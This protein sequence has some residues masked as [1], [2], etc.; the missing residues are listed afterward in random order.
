MATT[1]LCRTCGATKDIT[2]FYRRA[3]SPDGLA[4]KCKI[5]ASEY[6][7]QHRTKYPEREK[8]RHDRRVASGAKKASDAAYYQRNKAQMN[9]QARRWYEDHRE[10]QSDYH[11]RYFVENRE[12]YRASRKAY[13]ARTSEKAKADAKRWASE[14]PEKVAGR[15][16]RWN[17]E[18]PEKTRAAK[19]HYKRSDAGRSKARLRQLRMAGLDA[20]YLSRQ[21]IWE[22]DSGL[23]HLCGEPAE[24]HNWHLDHVIPLARGGSH[25]Y[26]NVAV[27]H[28]SCNLRK[29]ARSA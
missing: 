2:E 27:S 1:K 14:H 8:A 15:I 9:A 24:P 7:R 10:E 17:A 18:N 19:Q 29:G 20:E 11:R 22:R 4:P 12:E 3:A 6:A 21:M 26:D 16:Q 28:P 13:Y 25:T 23:C 5:C